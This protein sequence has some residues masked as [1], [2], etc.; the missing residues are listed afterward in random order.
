MQAR[1]VELAEKRGS[2]GFTFDDLA[3]AAVEIGA[4]ADEVARCL[5][6]ARETGYLADLGA[7]TLSDGTVIGPQR[8]S[9]A[10][11]VSREGGKGHTSDRRYADCEAPAR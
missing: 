4:T 7:D 11:A 9:L 1:L 6:H 8:F 10:T 3:A 2:Q 5:A